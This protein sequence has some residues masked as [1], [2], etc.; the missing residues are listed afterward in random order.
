MSV[1]TLLGSLSFFRSVLVN[2]HA[3]IL[4]STLLKATLRNDETCD[5][6]DGDVI[7]L[8]KKKG[9]RFSVDSVLLADF[10]R[11]LV[12]KRVLELGSGAGFIS[13][14]L[15]FHC[16]S[17]EK[18]VGIDLNEVVVNMAKRSICLNEL[19]SDITFIHGDLRDHKS[20][21]ESQSFDTVVCNPPFRKR[22]TGF[23][24]PNPDKA[25]ANHELTATLDDFFQAGFY[26]LR[27]GGNLIGIHC[28]DRLQDVLCTSAERGFCV[29]V[30]R[31][32]HSFRDSEGKFILF[33]AKKGAKSGLRVL[34]PLVIYQEEHLYTSEAARILTREYRT[35]NKVEIIS[36]DPSELR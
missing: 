14:T 6:V 26:A 29:K 24:S 25:M 32:V 31:F 15:A 36:D 1:H 20:L 30:L 11:P 12:K 28:A 9:W 34:P 27:N 16:S 8:Q 7:I 19:S 18:I 17:L 33:S 10:A 21:C 4:K 2:R 3:H 35:F 23:S 5:S 13:L 22:E